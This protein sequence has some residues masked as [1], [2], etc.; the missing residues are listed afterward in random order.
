MLK[1]LYM[2][3]GVGVLGFYAMSS[4]FGWELANSGSKSRLG[5]PFFYSGFRGGK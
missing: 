3:F 4:W 5:V 1:K 2:V